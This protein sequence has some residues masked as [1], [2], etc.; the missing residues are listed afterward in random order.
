MTKL[1]NGPGQDLARARGEPRNPRILIVRLSALGDTTLTLPLLFALRESLPNAF[2]GWVVGESAQPLLAG[3]APLDRVHVWRHRERSAAGL[4]RLAREIRREGYHLSLDPQGLTV[5]ALL[6]FLARIPSRLGFVHTR[7]ESRELAP[8]L[9]NRRIRVPEAVTHIALRTLHLGGPL[10]VDPAAWPS[11]KL[12]AYPQAAVRMRR[13]W[14]DQRLTDRTL[15]VGFGAGW[16]TR[17]WPAAQVATLV[18][19]AEQRGYRVL[20]LWGPA[21]R[22]NLHAWRTALGPGVLWAPPTDIPEMISLLRLCRAYA[23]PDSS[24]LHL[25]WLSGKPTF[26]WFGASDPARCAPL[27]DIHR[28]TAR[29][30]HHWRR[31]NWPPHPLGSLKA[32]EVVPLFLDWLHNVVEE[33]RP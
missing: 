24:P 4:Y 3:L 25:A 14:R 15:I 2:L 1:P 30:P 6:P 27:G 13:W 7:L 26:S 22:G 18:R 5:S 20:A 28:H 32:E 10:G 23:G 11:T 8:L 21:E 16:P 31:Q 17:I 9:I 29:G 33:A 12:P 19:E